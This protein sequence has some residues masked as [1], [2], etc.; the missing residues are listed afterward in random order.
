MK[1]QYQNLVIRLLAMILYILIY[2]VHGSPEK[3]F[4]F[5]QMNRIEIIMNDARNYIHEEEEEEEEEGS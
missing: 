5:M 2:E 1:T 4:R 3:E